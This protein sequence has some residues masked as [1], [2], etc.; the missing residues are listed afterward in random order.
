M[1]IWAAIRDALALLDRRDRRRLGVSAA[2]QMATS[3]LD[4]IGVALI[5]LVAA[6]SL[7]AVQGQH[8]PKFTDRMVSALG[9]ANA[10]EATRLGVL[11]GGAAVLLLAKS[12]VSPL[13]MA[14]VLRFLARRQAIVTA[15]LTK[16]LF[17]RPMTFIQ[18]RSSQE[19]ASALLQGAS[20]ATI[21]LLGQAVAGAAEMVLLIILA[22]T[23]L[24]VDPPVALGAIAFFG[25]FGVGMQRVLGH[26]VSNVGTE[27][28]QAEIAS[29]RS[30]QEAL[31][32]YREICVADRRALYVKRIQDLRIRAAQAAGH[33][34]TLYMLPKYAA[35]VALVVGAFSLAAVLFTTEPMA[36]AAGT[37]ALFIATVTRAM[38]SLLRLQ[39]AALAIRGAAA[40]AAPTFAL[41]QDLGHPRDAPQP[42][43]TR[44]AVRR[45]VESQHHDFVP[46]IEM[47]DVTFTYPAAQHPAIPGMT[48]LVEEG[49]SVAFVG[50]SGA[51]KSTLADV[52]LGVLQPDGGEVAVGGIPPAEAVRRW[53]GAIAYV[54]QEVM[55]VNDSIRANVALGLPRDAID[56]ELVWDAL[57]RAHL[58]EY[59][60][61]ETAGLDTQV[62]ERGIRISGGQRQRLGI[63]RA[64]FTRPR[65]LVLDEATSALDA[66]AEH[67]I[68]TM[69][70]DLEGEVTTLI[71]A[72]R[73]STIRHVDLVVY[74]EAGKATAK[75]SFD[76]VCARVPA[77]RRQ[78]DLMG[79]QPPCQAK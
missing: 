51:G 30:L 76:E 70:N 29:L 32:A 59:L 8:P 78:A 44:E 73:L 75:G 53:P 68:T 47:R 26:R 2:L 43:E 31:G 49:Q 36:V 28:L 57:H 37:F 23:L 65:L 20:A 63:A 13:L 1:K 24:I 66:E 39:S 56:D 40:T 19:T 5:G 60:R 33:L 25:F 17:S 14:R 52:I 6:V 3:L 74:L 7:A 35:E 72:H 22:G 9:L 38:P 12:I 41:A 11:A 48:L 27:S 4:F 79:L 42:E 34:Q 54:P 15:C 67:A 61:G 45:V 21:Q 46:R 71:I 77:L 69:V 55:L 62:G 64:L 58:A 18:Q 10:S 50:R 16:E